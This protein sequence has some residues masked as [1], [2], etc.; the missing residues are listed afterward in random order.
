M[1]YQRVGFFLVLCHE[2]SIYLASYT[3]IDWGFVSSPSLFC[4]VGDTV[5]CKIIDITD[6]K[7]PCSV[8]ALK[9]NPWVN[10]QERYT[11]GDIVP[12]VIIQYNKHGVFISIEAGISGLMHKSNFENEENLQN[13]YRMEN[14][15]NFKIARLE[16]SSKKIIFFLEDAPIEE[17]KH[18]PAE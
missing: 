14:S 4:S 11:I 12:G 1:L 2:S 3:E 18:T 6:G 9:E 17:E 15:Y 7:Y 8:K 16:P 10:I 5:R 13:R